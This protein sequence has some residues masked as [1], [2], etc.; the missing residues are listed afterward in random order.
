M[1]NDNTSFNW[2]NFYM[3]F[4]DK[5]LAYKNKRKEL[6]SILET[7]HEQAG[8]R[9][10]F[11]YDDQPLDDIC[12]F[13]VFGSFNKNIKNERRKALM[14]AIAGIIKIQSPIPSNFEGLPTLTAQLAWFF[15]S[16]TDPNR[17]PD[18]IDNLWNMFEAGISLANNPNENNRNVFCLHK[19]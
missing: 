5:L 7:A 18:D 15:C 14:E 19:L 9:Y 1:E 12:P 3:E 16:K 4:A 10:P 11:I 2:T 13:T 17:K 6:L 8:L